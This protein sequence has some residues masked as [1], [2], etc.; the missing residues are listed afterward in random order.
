MKKRQGRM[1][2]KRRG[3]FLAAAIL[4]GLFV[5]P[6]CASAETVSIP[7]K[8][9]YH[10]GQKFAELTF[11]PEGVGLG[12]EKD[13]YV[14]PSKY[15][16]SEAL[17][18]ATVSSAA[19]WSDILGD[20]AKNTV[21]WQM[22]VN[23]DNDQNASAGTTSL[24]SD[25]EKKTE[26]D[27]ENFIAAQLQNGK[28]LSVLD[29]G[30]LVNNIPPAGDYGYSQITIGRYFGAQRSS[31][32]DERAHEYGWWADTDTVLPTNE[33]ATDFVGTFRHELGHALGISLAREYMGWNLKAITAQEAKN[34]DTAD[35]KFLMRV[36]SDV[37]AA[38][39]W[40]LHLMD[41]RGVKAKAG[42]PIVTTKG[43]EALKAKNPTLTE[44]DVFLV[45]NEMTADGKG[46]AYFVGDHVTEA[47]D[48]ATF[49]GRS[50]LP[51]NGWE[52][53]P[54]F[55]GS[56]LQT[57]GMMSHRDYSNYTAFMEVE[58]AVM[59]DLGYDLDR[60]AYFGRSIYG[61][62]GTITNAQGFSARNTDGTAYTADYSTVPLGIGLH[63][64]GANNTVTQAANILTR[65]TGATGVRVD[66]S[67]NALHIPQGTE[68]HADGL[69]GNGV[70][71]AYGRHQKVE[72]AGTVTAA[73]QGGTGIR[74]D[75]GSSSNGAKDEYRGSYIR[76]LRNVAAWSDADD[77]DDA[78][79][80]DIVVNADGAAA[81]SAAATPG[82]IS[83]AKNL[84]LTDMD[85]NTYN[86]NVNELS[87]ALVTAYDLSG[88]LA[89]GEN[90]IYIG[91]NAFVENINV[92]EGASVKGNI[93]SDWKHFGE[94]A[95]EGAYNGVKGDGTDALAVQYG[96]KAYHYSFYIP[97]LV[98]N[99]NFNA[100]MA[101]DGNITGADNM[102]LFVNGGTLEYGGAADVVGVSVAEGASLFGGSY[103]VHD[104]SSKTDSDFAAR[105]DDTDK[106]NFVSHGTIGAASKDTDMH[107]VGNLVS[108]GTLTGIGGGSAGGIAVTGAA[109]IEGSTVT[110]TNALPGETMTVLDA[111]DLTGNVA[112]PEG[113]PYA[114]SGMLNATGTV[115]GNTLVVSAEAANH[116]GDGQEDAYNAMVNMYDSLSASGDTRTEEMRPLFSMNAS[117][118]KAALSSLS[119]NAAAQS[120]MLAQRNSLMGRL[121]ASRLTEAYALKDTE[122]KIPSAQLDGEGKG[123][124]EVPMKLDQPVESDFWF[125]AG[126]NWGDLSGNADYHGTALAVGWD[127]GIGGGSRF[128]VFVGHGWMGFSDNNANNRMRDTRLGLYFANQKGA[129]ASF[130]YLDYGWMKNHLQRNM[131]ALGLGA[132]AHYA[133]R[134]LELGGEYKYD[135]GAGTEKPWHFAPYVNMQ[136]SRLWQD[137][138]TESGAGIFGQRVSGMTNNYFAGGIGIELK[139]YLANGSYALR[140]GAKHAFTGANPR[141]RFG[142]AGGGGSYEMRGEQDVTHF[143]VSLGGEAEFAPGWTL[144]G[145]AVLERGAHDRDMMC[146][147]T[148]R[149]M[150]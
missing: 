99:L 65:G 51:V 100:D 39:A 129:N 40:A 84:P 37:T 110:V 50:A 3:K 132:D 55:E 13:W 118:A 117:E 71:I 78:E 123:A 102:K 69:R 47:L 144:S 30:T 5:L 12:N 70:L 142:Y 16:L 42:M 18:E 92:S 20:G 81:S 26:L 135:F 45:D 133:A 54:R 76:Y 38:N 48:G 24:H 119:S 121:I 112:N 82:F 15:T 1:L 91:R 33:Q 126:K 127:R 85:A 87:G 72:Q 140:F 94:E 141:L 11:F 108:D 62:G 97:D 46:F 131:A 73:G 115:D 88:T 10:N 104:M 77:G 59:Q 28:A 122:V 107:I 109:N 35:G 22:L 19:Y 23:T 136:L 89:G 43:F 17:M 67:E 103:T 146:A 114:A 150:W 53:K 149:R 111:A 56:H 83:E 80:L 96:G 63:I 31:D 124:I 4:A 41:Q 137:G 93:T 143:V 64:Y 2:S 86:A 68:I 61:N 58:L 138:Y 101:Y 49:F 14:D 34:Q 60:K 105:L 113:S 29:Q 125:K 134:I 57:A 27:G 52:N 44:S 74:F 98:T 79:D 32:I 6:S 36:H 90:A 128:G 130:V 66:G 75:F 8:Y 7:V 148:L 116:L 120:A 9:L 147:L 21:P 25:G 145:D 95:S 106:G 139:R